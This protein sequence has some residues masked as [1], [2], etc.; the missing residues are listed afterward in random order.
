MRRCTAPRT[1][2]SSR[3]TADEGFSL[4]ELMVSMVLMGVVF[5]ALAGTLVTSLRSLNHTERETVATATVLEVIEEAASLPW[6]LAVVYA[7]DAAASGDD[8]E[9]WR[10][11]LDAGGTY[12]G[13]VLITEPGPATPADRDVRVPLPFRNITRGADT[14]A[15]DLYPTWVDLTGDGVDD[16][17]RFTVVASWT[18]RFGTSRELVTVSDRAPT[19]N[20]AYSTNS[21]TRVLYASTTPSPVTLDGDTGLTTED[22]VIEVRFNADVST[23]QASFTALQ[24]DGSALA[25]TVNLAPAEYAGT[26]AIRWTATLPDGGHRFANG[27]ADVTITALDAA[28]GTVTGSAVIKAQGGPFDSV[29]APPTP[30]PDD[31]DGDAT[32]VEI[33]GSIVVSAICV[34][35]GNWRLSSPVTATFTVTGIDA[36]DGNVTVS[37]PYWTSKNKSNPG[38]PDAIGTVSAAPQG[39]GTWQ[40]TIPAGGSAKFA[41][42]ESI[43][44]SIE[45]VRSSDGDNDAVTSPTHAISSC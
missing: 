17:K 5:S 18:D 44:F 24:A 4:V 34:S 37:Y 11:R 45:A 13:R 12:E 9:R 28:A 26:A 41:P 27:A 16:A 22:V 35:Q 38:A 15:L 40:A 14:Y 25:T 3:G 30:P 20:E 2:D 42:G 32:P 10:S 43:S 36:T 31:D 39:G 1:R 19:Q 29:G 6:E 7:G 33:Q 8:G 21:G 23:V